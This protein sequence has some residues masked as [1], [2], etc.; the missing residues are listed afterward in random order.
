MRLTKVAL[1]L[2]A[3]FAVM[4][5]GLSSCNTTKVISTKKRAARLDPVPP[6]TDP[7][8]KMFVVRNKRMNI[9]GHE[10]PER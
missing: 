6:K 1:F 5:I 9:L 3:V 10:R 2:L 7:V 4:L 8:A